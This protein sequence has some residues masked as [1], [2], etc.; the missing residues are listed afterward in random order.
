LVYL[1]YPRYL[2]LNFQAFSVVEK[3][4]FKALLTYLRPSLVPR[5][6]PSR[7]TVTDEIFSKS[8]RIKGLLSEQFKALASRVSFTFDAGTSRAYDPYLT[9]TGHWIDDKW[10]LHEQVL[11]FREIVGD[12]SGVNTGA[13]LTNILQDYGLVDPD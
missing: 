6:L 2:C 11:A 1:S 3:D 5:D 8:I 9:V 12:H 10:D 13:L 4:S 7:T